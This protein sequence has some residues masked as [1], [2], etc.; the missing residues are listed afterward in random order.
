MSSQALPRLLELANQSLLKEKA[1]AI[2]ALEELSTEFFPTLVMAAF[3]GRHCEA[4]K[5]MVQAWPFVCLPLGALI[6]DQWLHW[7]TLQAVFDGINGLFAQVV[8][9]RRWKLQ[10]LDLWKHAHQDFWNI[11]SGSVTHVLSLMELGAANPMTKRQKVEDSRVEEKQS[12]GPL[13]ALLDLCLREGTPDELLTY[14]IK[15]HLWAL[16]LDSV[17]FLKGHLD[18]VLRYLKTPLETLSITHCLIHLSLYPNVGQLKDLNLH[19]ISLMNLNPGPLKYLLKRLTATLWGLDLDKCGIMDF[20]FSILLPTD[21][22]QLI[23]NPISIAVL[24]NLLRFTIRLSKLS[25]MLYPA[26]VESY[27]DTD[28]I[29]HPGRLAQFHA[30]LRQMLQEVGQP[31]M[32]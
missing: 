7:E 6:K 3:T 12:S 4:L 2:T 15:K 21:N 11:W 17:Y 31:S 22:P 25:H 8:H 24:E 19:G 28:G 32:I 10:V 30:K 9:P 26:P 13:E 1:L 29:L 14:L 18:Q 20:Q 16:H 27:E 23:W 5:A